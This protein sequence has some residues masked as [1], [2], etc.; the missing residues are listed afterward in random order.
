MGVISIYVLSKS[1]GLIYHY[2]HLNVKSEIEKTFIY[3]LELKLA[4]LNRKL[5]VAFGQKDGVSV[6]Q[7]LLSVNGRP[8]V[9]SQLED[10]TVVQEFLDNSS[11]FPATLKFGKQKLTT[12][13]K[14]VL[15][16]IFKNPYYIVPYIF[17]IASMFYPLFAIASQLSPEVK[18]SG[19]EVLEADSF[20][21]Y[22]YQTLT[23]IFY[24][25]VIS[26]MRNVH[27]IF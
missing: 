26:M 9:G 19:I 25:Q 4:E 22:C 16:I 14:I 11:N 12:N 24:P 27:S 23:G 15:G 20:K 17:C 2:D 8:V 5:T 7:I 18:S 21:L 13:D 1:G 6:G 3:P 10:G